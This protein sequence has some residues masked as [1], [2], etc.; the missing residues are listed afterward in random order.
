MFFFGGMGWGG[1]G[2]GGETILFS[3]RNKLKIILIG[4]IMD[5]MTESGLPGIGRICVLLEMVWRENCTQPPG[6]FS[7]CASQIPQSEDKKVVIFIF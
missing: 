6:I 4:S 1:G 5:G 7:Y 2:E 3:D